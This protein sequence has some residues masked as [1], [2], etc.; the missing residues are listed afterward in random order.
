MVNEGKKG[1]G[2][3]LWGKDING[4]GKRRR[5]GEEKNGTWAGWRGEIK[6]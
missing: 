3:F 1:N 5:K 4:K 6:G 2:T